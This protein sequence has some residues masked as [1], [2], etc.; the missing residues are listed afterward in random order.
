[1]PHSSRLYQGNL[2]FNELAHAGGNRV[3]DRLRLPICAQ[4]NVDICG[5]QRCIFILVL[6][7][8]RSIE[9]GAQTDTT[10][11]Q[12]ADNA[13]PVITI[14]GQHYNNAVGSSDAASEG[15]VLGELMQDRPL[16]RPGEVLETVPG[17]VV[18]QHSGDGKAN[19]Y[20]LRGYNLDH[21]TDFA[22]SVDGVPVNMPTNAHGQGYSDLNFLIPELVDHIDYRKGTYFAENGDFSSAGSADIQY[23]HSLDRNL[24][25]LT[26]GYFGY[27]R[28]LIAGS[29]TL[30][31]IVDSGPTL[32]GALELMEENGPW[33]VPESLHKVNGLA[34]L[35]DGTRA[36]GWSIDTISY[37]ADWNSTDQVPLTLIESGKL[38]RYSA[39][40]P[41][42]GG[43]SGRALLSGEWHSHDADGYAKISAYFQHVRLQLWSDFSFYELRPATGDQF[44]QVENRDMTGVKAAKG[45]NHDLFGHDTVTEV[46]LQVRHDNIHV[47]LL[48]TQGRIAFNTVSDDLVGQTEAGVYA[49]NRTA[50]TNWLRSVIGVRADQVT[51]SMTALNIP[52][53][54]GNAAQS[55][56]SPKMA[57]V[58][59][60]WDKTELFVD[61]GEGFH[62]NDARGAIDKLDPT[63]GAPALKVPAIAGSWGNEIGVRT[64]AVAGLQSSLTLWCLNSASEL[65][66]NADSDIGSTTA[67]GASKRYGA[68]WNNH[69]AI[70][71]WLL[72]DADLAWTHAR[73]KVNNDNGVLGDFIP[74]AVPKVGTLALTVNN[75]GAWLGE[76]NTRYIGAYPLS[77]DGVQMGPSAIVT[78][79]RI[80]RELTH[81][82]SL[83]VNA[84]NI[85]NRQYYDIAYEQDYRISPASHIVPAGVTVH[86]GEPRELR[87]TLVY[88]M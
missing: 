86:P 23:R 12:L 88:K 9:A 33:T 41:S 8:L 19:Q 56:V 20:F 80:Q 67:N 85:F 36:D 15:V 30:V 45:W 74:N 72:L 49:Q 5:L 73:F 2:L 69:M 52:Q 79:L 31:G 6:C 14:S 48:D 38:G 78:N 4:T 22:T 59:G 35:S 83:S 27:Q 18:T 71:R 7:C 21:G 34:R 58:L 66:Y 77:Q 64:E 70:T 51:M 28:A 37:Q 65:I 55:K 46:G 40:D 39:F 84:L 47:S 44:S 63:T 17:L 1:V 32:L 24:L 82:L 61:S 10:A 87:L 62:T 76:V 26:E 68:E 42:D 57:L 25:T 13:I 11:F 3:F 81:S 50:W 43:N 29:T 16:L 75:L 54:S 60:P 53:N